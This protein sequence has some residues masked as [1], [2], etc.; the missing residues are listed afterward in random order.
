MQRTR[1]LQTIWALGVLTGTMACDSM[2]E[3]TTRLTQAIT[4]EDSAA[5]D[6]VADAATDTGAAT[7]RGMD[8]DCDHP[9][10]ERGHPG[11]APPEFGALDGAACAPPVAAGVLLGRPPHGRGHLAPIYDGD[12]SH[13][14]DETE[15][16]SLQAD[17]A[18]GCSAR[19]ATLI[20]DF[21]ED[22]DSLLS[23]AEWDAAREARR[24]AHAEERASLDTDGDGEISSDEHDAAR[25]AL[26]AAWDVDGSGDL[27]D[28]ERA[29]MRVDLQALVRAGERLPPLPFM[30]A[31]HGPGRG[32]MRPAHDDGADDGADD[33]E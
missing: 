3:T 18:A 26:V 10:G 2:V 32:G 25:A 4:A 5:T 23:Q 15:L 29:A 12:D 20:A 16:A 6:D 11:E 14:L 30:G 22:G 31:H 1:T 24:A 7:D 13:N 9:A 28:A 8:G 21:D 33:G 17:V 19:N 27:D